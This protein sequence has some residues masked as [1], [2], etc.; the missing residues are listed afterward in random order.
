[1]RTLTSLDYVLAQRVR[2]RMIAH[3]QKAFEQVDA[4]LTPTTAIVAPPILP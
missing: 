4:I 2:T 1:A 3:F